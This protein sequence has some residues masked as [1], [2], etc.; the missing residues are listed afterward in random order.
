MIRDA[1]KNGLLSLDN[2]RVHHSKPVTA[3]MAAQVDNIERFYLPSYSLELNPQERLKADLENKR[4]VKGGLCPSTPYCAMRPM[5]TLE[6]P[7][8]N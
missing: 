5:T 7:I 4:S 6:F 1:G 3:W 2:F 8:I